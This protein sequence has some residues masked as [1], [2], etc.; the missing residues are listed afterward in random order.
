MVRQQAHL[1]VVVGDLLAM[2][3]S[4]LE[5][6][7]HLATAT[8]VFLLDQGLQSSSQERELELELEPA[9]AQE[10]EENVAGVSLVEELAAAEMVVGLALLQLW[11]GCQP[12][13][14]P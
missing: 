8:Q 5:V 11:G 7:P 4:A 9:L 13:A 10:Q 2:K 12:A 3:T 14:N 1:E 6:T